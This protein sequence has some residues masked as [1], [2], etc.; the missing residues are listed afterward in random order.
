MNADWAISQLTEY[1]AL[2][3]RFSMSQYGYLHPDQPTADA[4]AAST[5]VIESIVAEVLPDWRAR[6]AGASSPIRGLRELAIQAKA[7]IER[8]QELRDNLDPPGPRIS[9]SSFHP[10]VWNA[11]SS[12]WAA[13]QF[14]DGVRAAAREVNAM[15]QGK[16]GRKDIGEQDL[17]NQAFSLDAPVPGKPRLRLLAAHTTETY[18]NLQKG[19]MA[20]G[21]VCFG[22]IRNVL[23]HEAGDL[24]SPSEMEALEY[25]AAFSIL[26]RWIDDSKVLAEKS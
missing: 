17:V 23:N 22:G 9:A 5:P 8:A 3:T 2:C 25:L 16:L 4:I 19:A 12:A 6:S 26:A 7:L 20:L 18:R 14:G 24:A 1:I 11:A 15:L 13:S 10:V 21:Q